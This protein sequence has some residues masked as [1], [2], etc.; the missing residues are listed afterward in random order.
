MPGG[1]R[2]ALPACS[3]QI[4]LPVD[5]HL[6]C[7]KCRIKAWGI[8]GL[9]EDQRRCTDCVSV[10]PYVLQDIRIKCIYMVKRAAARRKYKAKKLAAA[11]DPGLTAAQPHHLEGVALP[12]APT[13][14]LDKTPT[15]PQLNVVDAPLQCSTPKREDDLA[16][17]GDFSLHSSDMASMGV[18]NVTDMLGVL[19]E[20]ETEAD[21]SEGTCEQLAYPR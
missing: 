14:A 16:S 5:K 17:L 7:H 8:E 1:P 13:P 10:P 9:C 11:G 19:D 12:P 4:R 6:A 18:M 15:L 21:S 2:K 20:P 3:H